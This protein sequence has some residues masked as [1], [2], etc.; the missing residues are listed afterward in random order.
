MFIYSEHSLSVKVV[1]RE[2]CA[3]VT[4]GTLTEGKFHMTNP[5]SSYLMAI[6]E[7][8][9]ASEDHNR[10]GIVIGICVVDISTSK[11][12]IGQVCDQFLYSIFF[13]IA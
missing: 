6:T 8:S 11:F 13:V 4:K 10:E 3:M 12:V 9:N 5:D 7:Q 1:K 2:I